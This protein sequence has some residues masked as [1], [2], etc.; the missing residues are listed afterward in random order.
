VTISIGI[1]EMIPNP[2]THKEKLIRQADTAMYD[3]KNIGRN[4]CMI[5]K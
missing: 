3:A 1:S 2:N 4:K 5:Y